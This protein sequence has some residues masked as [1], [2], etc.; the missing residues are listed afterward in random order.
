MTTKK[1]TATH[2]SFEVARNKQVESGLSDAHPDAIAFDAALA[3][4]EHHLTT[5]RARGAIKGAKAGGG[6][7]GPHA[8]AHCAGEYASRTLRV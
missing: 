4:V 8:I 5:S 6:G 1:R 2:A 7:R 3:V